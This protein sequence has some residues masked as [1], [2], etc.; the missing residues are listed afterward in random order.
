MSD[1]RAENCVLDG[2]PLH[3][4]QLEIVQMLGRVLAVNTVIDEHRQVSFVN[5]GEVV[6]SHLQAV[7]FIR[8]FAQVPVARRFKTVVTSAAGY[9]LDTTYYQTVKGMVAPDR[10]PGAGRQPDRRVRMLGGHG[11]ERVRRCPAAAA[12]AGHGR[13]LSRTSAGRPTPT[14]TSGRPRCS[15]SPCAWVASICTAP[16]C[17]APTVPLP[18]CSMVDSVSDAVARC[19]EAAG[20]RHIAVIPEGP[21]VVP[22][23]QPAA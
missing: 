4:E 2:N 12:R 14:S 23:Y 17:V 19:V 18:G 13:L 21:Y 1:P 20:D 8:R 11:F 5:Y 16:G 15:S 9:P 6:A 22:V 10:H 7:E 3:R